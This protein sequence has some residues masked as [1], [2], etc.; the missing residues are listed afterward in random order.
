MQKVAEAFESHPRHRDGSIAEDAVW[1][2]LLWFA[3]LLGRFAVFTWNVWH[4][5]GWWWGSLPFVA[6]YSLGTGV[7]VVASFWQA[8]GRT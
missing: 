5:G 8:Q 1:G 6:A 3:L 7:L 4:V 2:L